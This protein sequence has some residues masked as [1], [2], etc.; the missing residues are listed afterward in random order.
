[1]PSNKLV[2]L[3]LFLVLTSTIASY[4]MSGDRESTGPGIPGRPHVPDL[5]PITGAAHFDQETIQV[6][7][8]I[9]QECQQK[10][11]NE[12]KGREESEAN[13][14]C[15]AK[16]RKTG[17]EEA[18]EQPQTS[19]AQPLSTTSTQLRAESK[20]N[21][22][23]ESKLKYDEEWFS[24]FLTQI[25]DKL[26]G[27]GPNLV[28]MIAE[29]FLEREITVDELN[30]GII[31]RSPYT[32]RL[33]VVA[34]DDQQIT[35][36]HIKIIGRMFPNLRELDLGNTRLNNHG[37]R[38]LANQ[39][40]ACNLTKLDISKN[41]VTEA[42]LEVISNFTNLKSLTIIGVYARCDGK[43]RSLN[44]VGLA[45]I[46]RAPCAANLTQLNISQN[47][48]T[49]AGLEASIAAF[50]SL[51]DFNIEQNYIDDAGLVAIAGAPC[52]AKLTQLNISR[53]S[54]TDAGLEAS[55]AA[56]INLKGLNIGKYGDIGD[57]G[58]AA[59]AKAPCASNLTYLNLLSNQI[60]EKGIVASIGAFT[61]LTDLNIGLNEHIGDAGFAALAQAP[62]AVKLIRLGI[63]QIGI[64]GVGVQNNIGSFTSLR[65]LDIRGNNDLGD[66]GF[67]ALAQAPCAGDLTEL[68]VNWD[69][70]NIAILSNMQ[71]FT[72]LTSLNISHNGL[73][74]E[75]FEIIAQAPCAANL[76]QLN[77]KDNGITDAGL[78]ASIGA[79]I[80]LR[81][82]N[83]QQN[84][85]SNEGVGAIA[86]APCAAHL[87][88][89]DLRGTPIEELEVGSFTNLRRLLL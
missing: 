72:N 5:P 61:S 58:L 30:A 76:I 63:R 9:A 13:F 51:E 81:G 33:W 15:P 29:H 67:V 40:F 48:I 77:V 85:I 73:S 78:E 16:R 69:M 38:V 70:A 3:L 49:D 42:G 18:G 79:F 10:Q 60:T 17:K 31:T 35:G 34:E 52:A 19:Q 37:L 21:D 47:N 66:A 22:L 83:L 74:D 43:H 25:E 86:R 44:D 11:E 32:V 89:L 53:N 39:S 75:A 59:I 56:F 88:W 62:C 20:A 55:I 46:A 12:E 71:A 8:K 57:V 50:I 14:E 84:D 7:N 27:R 80:N 54:I 64:S 68:M 24:G 26:L 36:Q 6:L 4:G 87:I 41:A 1:M 45:V 2:K 82:L 28:N 23:T 65:S